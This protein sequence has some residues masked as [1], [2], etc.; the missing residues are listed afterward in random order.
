MAKNPSTKSEPAPKR[1]ADSADDEESDGDI[2]RWA[3]CAA[4]GSPRSG[5]P[6]G[7]D[8]LVGL[9]AKRR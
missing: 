2:K 8:V 3:D 9:E 7:K 5:L 6:V 4:K 1:E